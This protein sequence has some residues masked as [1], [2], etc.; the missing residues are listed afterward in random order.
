MVD[1]TKNKL[2]KPEKV[3]NNQ[4]KLKIFTNGKTYK[5]IVSSIELLQSAVE[6]KKK[7]S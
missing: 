2:P 1:S 4:E 3:I 5:L 6:K 7:L